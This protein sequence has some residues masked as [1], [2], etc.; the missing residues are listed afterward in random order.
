M[1]AHQ[2]PSRPPGAPHAPGLSGP[3]GP[4]R[5]TSGWAVASL[6]F[7]ILWLCGAGSLLAVVLGVIALARIRRTGQNGRG[8]AVAGLIL[9]VLGLLAGAGLALIGRPAD[10]GRQSEYTD[11]VLDARGTG[12]VATAGVTYSFG[13]DTSDSAHVRLPWRKEERRELR[14]LDV[15]RIDV[16]NHTA[17]GS[18]GCRITVDGRVAKTAEVAGGHRTASCLYNP[19]TAH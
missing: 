4:S 8:L 1:S 19:I 18:V 16:R 7:S 11:I 3:S 13:G 12:G 10:R 6:I 9:G 14:E 5:G 17:G 15:V 2:P